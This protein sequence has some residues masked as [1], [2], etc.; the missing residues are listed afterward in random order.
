MKN[1][2]TGPKNVIRT[3][4]MRQAKKKSGPAKTALMIPAHSCLCV[5]EALKAGVIDQ[6]TELVA[7]EKNEWTAL[8]MAIRLD[9]LG[10]KNVTIV[11]KDLCKIRSFDV[12]VF[13]FVY[14]DT[15][16]HLSPL[17]QFWISTVLPNH[18]NIHTQLACTFINSDR[19]NWYVDEDPT[20][21]GYQFSEIDKTDANCKKVAQRIKGC[22][23]SRVK[24]GRAYKNGDDDAPMITVLFGLRRYADK[25]H[26]GSVKSYDLGYL[27]K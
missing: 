8:D 3:E 20:P 22:I 15:C 12:E 14:I 19:G 24:Y 5:E 18:T 25:S 17:M 23:N 6:N 1:W 2:S 7:V 11:R 13:D 21:C 9:E 27:H 10:M 16:C 26:S 4:L